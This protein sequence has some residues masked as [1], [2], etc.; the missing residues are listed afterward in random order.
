[1]GCS[2]LAAS[3][4]SSTMLDSECIELP[5]DVEETRRARTRGSSLFCGALNGSGAG[6]RVGGLGSGRCDTLGP[7][8]TG[9]HEALACTPE[10]WPSPRGS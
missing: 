3:I 7:A 6:S 5:D 1:M 10:V 2:A 9:E 8:Q 4:G